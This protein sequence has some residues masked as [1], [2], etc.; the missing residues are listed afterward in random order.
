M[1]LIALVGGSA[2][3][4]AGLSFLR[5]YFKNSYNYSEVNTSLV[6]TSQRI[7]VEPLCIVDASLKNSE[8]LTDVQHNVLNMYSGFY[9]QTIAIAL[10]DKEMKVVD[11]LSPY[12]TKVGLTDSEKQK[13]MQI[14]TMKEAGT[15]DFNK[16]GNWALD[17]VENKFFANESFKDV[18]TYKK[19]QASLE[20][21]NKNVFTGEL[22]PKASMEENASME[23]ITQAIKE[24]K[25]ETRLSVGKMIPVT[26]REKGLD[27]NVKEM[28]IPVAIHLV[29]G[30]LRSDYLVDLLAIKDTSAIDRKIAYKS[31]KLSFFADIIFCRDLYTQFRRNLIR[32]KSGYFKTNL[33]NKSQTAIDQ[34]LSGKKRTTG[35]TTITVVSAQTAKAIEDKLYIKL[36]KFADR[37]SFFVQSGLMIMVVVDDD[38]R[39]VKFYFHDVEKPLEATFN[40]IKKAAK[41]DPNITDIITALS[42]GQAPRL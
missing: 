31:G 34:I 3:V 6:T 7:R 5:S 40:D 39:M 12:G 13:E 42:M 35:I 24:I 26:I 4:S 23:D 30:Y 22:L 41:N 37:N 2:V 8:I 11:K 10:V 20:D 18:M 1:P 27:G 36:D 19:I 25:D 14:K 15:Q 17:K 16:A 32:D 9:L 29:G 38:Y 33:S 21:S 28:V